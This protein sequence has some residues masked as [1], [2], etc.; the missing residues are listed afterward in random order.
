VDEL[1]SH[2][3]EV[4]ERDLQAIRLRRAEVFDL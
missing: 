4:L 2:L 1:V 3:D